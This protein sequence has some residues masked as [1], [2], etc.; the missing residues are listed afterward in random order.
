MLVFRPSN[1]TL[2][3][4]VSIS[5]HCIN[6]WSST[7]PVTTQPILRIWFGIRAPREVPS[8]Q[9]SNSTVLLPSTTYAT[10]LSLTPYIRK[11]HPPP[12]IMMI[13]WRYTHATYIL[14]RVSNHVRMG[15][16]YLTLPWPFIQPPD[17]NVIDAPGRKLS[18]CDGCAGVRRTNHNCK[19]LSHT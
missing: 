6:S 19:S 2:S 9:I 3:R 1:Q 14:R 10:S 16:L 13:I 15:A 17:M 12:P 11:G 7:I 8:I 4:L 5:D 18:G